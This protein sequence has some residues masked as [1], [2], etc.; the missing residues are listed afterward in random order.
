MKMK[1]PKT[2]PPLIRF[3]V[4]GDDDRYR[5]MAFRTINHDPMDDRTRFYLYDREKPRIVNGTDNFGLLGIANDLRRFRGI[6]SD[7]HW[8]LMTLPPRPREGN[9][10]LYAI[11]GFNELVAVLK[12]NSDYSMIDANRP[13]FPKSAE[14]I[15]RI[16]DTVITNDLIGIGHE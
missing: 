12:I 10:R 6:L 7:R 2:Y 13:F 5:L 11:H 14:G 9:G 4:F 8:E 3:K 1:K 15:H 16:V